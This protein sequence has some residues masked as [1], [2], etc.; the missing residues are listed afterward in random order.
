M[1]GLLQRGGVAACRAIDVKLKDFGY[2][3]VFVYVIG[4]FLGGKLPC[5]RLSLASY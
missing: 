5:H 4:S 3:V 1:K 2:G